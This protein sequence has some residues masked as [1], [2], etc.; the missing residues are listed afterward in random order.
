MP[1]IRRATSNRCYY[2]SHQGTDVFYGLLQE[3]VELCS[4]PDWNFG[5]SEEMFIVGIEDAKWWFQK[6]RI[7]E[8]RLSQPKQGFQQANWSFP[9]I[10]CSWGDYK[11]ISVDKVLKLGRWPDMDVTSFP[12]RKPSGN[13]R[14][15]EL[16]NGPLIDD[17][18]Q[19]IRK[20]GDFPV[21][22]GSYVKLP[23]GSRG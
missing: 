16:E 19:P 5:N 14:V 10:P 15:C 3:E 4:P 20:F 9:T 18:R 1:R 6:N 11:D 8:V 21:R 17:V 13:S 12:L 2:S 7:D 23:E 22:Y